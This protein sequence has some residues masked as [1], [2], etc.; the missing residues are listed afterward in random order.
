[1]PVS[2]FCYVVIRVRLDV[3]RLEIMYLLADNMRRQP[4]AEAVLILR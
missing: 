4:D 3:I 2:V 1:M